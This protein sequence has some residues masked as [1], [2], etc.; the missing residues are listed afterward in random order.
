MNDLKDLITALD[1]FYLE[2][3]GFNVTQV[4]RTGTLWSLAVSPYSKSGDTYTTEEEVN[5]SSI[6]NRIEGK[7]T[8]EK[9]KWRVVKVEELKPGVYELVVRKEENEKEDC[10][11]K[12]E[13]VEN[14]N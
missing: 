10:E 5:I 3:T 1:G 2:K 11:N 14:E 7:Y 13:H 8:T 12:E 6:V 9:E 4:I